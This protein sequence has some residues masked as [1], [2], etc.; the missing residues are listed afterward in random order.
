VLVLT[1]RLAADALPPW[2]YPIPPPD[3]PDPRLALARHLLRPLSSHTANVHLFLL[4]IDLVIGHVFPEL[5]VPP[6]E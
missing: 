2:L 1:R 4:I 6:P 3:E 5:V